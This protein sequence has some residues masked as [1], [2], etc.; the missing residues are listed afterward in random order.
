MVDDSD[1]EE[2]KKSEKA[3]KS[4]TSSSTSTSVVP[5]KGS[6]LREIIKTQKANGSF[7]Y[8]SLV[9]FLVEN[10]AYIIQKLGSIKL[11]AEA[12]KAALGGA[13]GMK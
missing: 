12:I 13:S 8:D 6:E 10:L 5:E 3:P 1:E 2:E 4:K 11:N 9:L 7:T